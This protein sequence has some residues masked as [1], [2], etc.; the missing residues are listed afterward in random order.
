MDSANCN[1][2]ANDTRQ[3]IL[4]E[5]LALYSVYGH[6]KTT[7]NDIAKACGVSSALV[8]KHIGTKSEL[9]DQVV[10]MIVSRRITELKSVIKAEHQPARKLADWIDVLAKEQVHSEQSGSRLGNTLQCAFEEDWDAAN[11]A[12]A[13]HRDVLMEIVSQGVEA[14]EFKVSTVDHAVDVLLVGLQ[15]FIEPSSRNSRSVRIDADSLGGFVL[16]GL[17]CDRP[18]SRA[19]TQ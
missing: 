6:R 4:D 18:G 16:R 13:A 7:I 10:D 8:H 3:R 5:A 17:G 14:G 12:R 9:S 19:A 2:S 11:A 15:Q 1:L